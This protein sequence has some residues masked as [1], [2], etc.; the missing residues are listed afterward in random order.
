MYYVC[1]ENGLLT[2]DVD[3]VRAGNSSA[4]FFIHRVTNYDNGPNFFTYGERGIR[5]GYPTAPRS[6]QS[7]L[8][9]VVEMETTDRPLY[10]RRWIRLCGCTYSCHFFFGFGLS[11]TCYSH[12]LRWNC[13]LIQT[14]RI[15]KKHQ[16]IQSICLQVCTRE[17]I[18]IYP[19]TYHFGD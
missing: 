14:K 10:V 7:L 3:D 9:A 13:R 5:S 4:Y 19:L 16:S 11:G 2:N 1:E 17:K 6:W 18:N 8:C 15:S 12:V